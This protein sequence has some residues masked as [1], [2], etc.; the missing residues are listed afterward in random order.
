MNEIPYRAESFQP[1]LCRGLANVV[2]GFNEASG[3]SAAL[4]AKQTPKPYP[5]LL[6]SDFGFGVG[7]VLSGPQGPLAARFRV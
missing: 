1:C 6:D 4:S 2:E 5:R 3:A 7:G